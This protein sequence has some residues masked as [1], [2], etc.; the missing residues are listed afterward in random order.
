MCGAPAAPVH[1][2]AAV[3]RAAARPGARRSSG[4]RIIL[5]GDVPSP[6]TPAVGL[7]VPPALPEGAGR[8]ASRT[9]PELIARLGDGAEHGA[10]CHFPVADGEDLSLATPAIAEDQRVIES[11]LIAGA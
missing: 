1:R 9:E 11:G 8:P 4:E 5:A 10:A 2:R 6:I 7:P 3:G